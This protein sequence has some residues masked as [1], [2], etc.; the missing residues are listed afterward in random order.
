MIDGSRLIIESMVKSAAEVYVGYPITPA[1]WL[2]AYAKQRFPTFLAAPD[3]ISA[4][5]WASGFSASGK[6]PVTGTS[7]PGFSLMIESLNM[8]FMMELP[9][10]IVLVQRLGPSTGSA[11]TGAQ[12]DLLLLR[13]AI[14]GGFQ[15]PVFCPSNLQDCWELASESVATALKL[16]TPVIL[17]SSKEMLM[18]NQSFD[19]AQLPDMPHSEWPEY[20]GN[21]S[22]HSYE[23]EN[24]QA[25]PFLPVGNLQQQVRLNASTHGQAGLIQKATPEALGNTK[26][27]QTKIDYH[28]PEFT[29]YEYDHEQNS[30]TLLVTY[31]ISAGAARQALIQQRAK[32]HKVSLLV[33]KTLLPFS[34][35]IFDIF[36]EFKNL[37]LIEE[38]HSGLL[39]EILFGKAINPRLKKANKIGSMITPS[40]IEKEVELCQ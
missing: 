39:S 12:G 6:F 32:G 5:Q 36:S 16:R 15:I 7:F 27:L 24:N 23:T 10:V 28:L 13:G 18:T 14:S 26:R 30:Q 1:N 2:Y 11:T 4:L 17:L 20:S 40:E 33:I 8:A 31:G 34:S 37:V 19:L 21:G 29:F 22:Y 38:N 9:M 35:T 3:E 25:P